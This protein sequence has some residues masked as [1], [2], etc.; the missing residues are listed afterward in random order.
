MLYVHSFSGHLRKGWLCCTPSV[1]TCVRVGCAVS[2]HLLYCKTE[3]PKACLSIY[4]YIINDNGYSCN[5]TS[6]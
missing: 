6:V 5:I 3:P 4:D 2:G 1:D